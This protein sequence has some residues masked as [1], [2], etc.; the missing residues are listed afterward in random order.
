MSVIVP[1]RFHGFSP[2]TLNLA[3]TVL[4]RICSP[5]QRPSIENPGKT[6][7]YWVHKGSMTNT[8]L[9]LDAG[10]SREPFNPAAMVSTIGTRS[11]LSDLTQNDEETAHTPVMVASE[12]KVEWPNELD[13]ICNVGMTSQYEMCV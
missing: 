4:Q 13:Y 12:V 8:R 1:A 10:G 7:G 3:Q 11:K 2:G 6:T 5:L 9:L